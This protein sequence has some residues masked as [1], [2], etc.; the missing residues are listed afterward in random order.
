MTEYGPIEPATKGEYH[1]F[2]RYGFAAEEGPLGGDAETDF[3]S[4]LF[5][6]R[7]VYDG[8]LRAGCKRYAFEAYVRDDTRTVGGLGAL[9]T[10]PEYRG[11]GYA[12]TLCRAACREYSAEGVGLVALWPFSTPFYRGLGWATAH[13]R[14]RFDLTP[15]LLPAHEPGGQYRRLDAD[16]WEQL[17]AVAALS[18]D[19]VTLSMRRSEAWWRERTLTSWTGGAEPFVYGYERDGDL[20]GY[21]VYTVDDSDDSSERTL[22]VSAFAHV[23]REANRS[24]LAF[25]RRHGAQIDRVVLERPTTSR[26]LD[27]VE[28]PDTVT[29]ERTPGPMARLTGFDP[30]ETLDWSG[31][32]RPLTVAVTDPL[33]GATDGVFAVSGDGIERR[34][35]T[36]PD[37]TTDIGTLTQLYLGRYDPTTAEAVA[38]LDVRTDAARSTLADVFPERPVY[39]GAFF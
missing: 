16:D 12:R 33:C 9:A 5:D 8:G 15:E 4:H 30:L 11:Q 27:L 2:T 20:A 28:N 26:L 25:L 19:G 37:L 6:L 39:L 24:L 29:C 22:S 17:G 7:G 34:D 3:D 1:R 35:D 18:R 36:D 38:G 31:L 13:D 21:L 10:P 23:D 32:D 14:Y